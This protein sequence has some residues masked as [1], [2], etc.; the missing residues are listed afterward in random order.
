SNAFDNSSFFYE[1]PKF[2]WL[3]RVVI[4]VKFR[5]EID[6]AS[7]YPI[8]LYDA[9]IRCISPVFQLFKP[10]NF[11]MFASG[12]A[13]SPSYSLRQGVLSGSNNNCGADGTVGSITL[14]FISSDDLTGAIFNARRRFRHAHAH[15]LRHRGRYRPCDPQRHCVARRR[16]TATWPERV[17]R[18]ICP[19]HARDVYFGLSQR[20]SQGRLIRAPFFA[21]VHESAFGPQRTWAASFRCDAQLHIT[22]PRFGLKCCAKDIYPYGSA[23]CAAL[24]YARSTP[25]VAGHRRS[26]WNRF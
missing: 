21:A 5:S 17:L 22:A 7:R 12:L 19:G 20:I 24:V 9:L 15:C 4:A 13:I 6:A 18:R 2:T 1:Q 10:S 26:T 3:V 23:I 25:F 11:V 8:P 16:P 14:D